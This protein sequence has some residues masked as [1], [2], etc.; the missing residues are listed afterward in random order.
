MECSRCDYFSLLSFFTW[1]FRPARCLFSQRDFP[2]SYEPAYQQSMSI[3]KQKII[4]TDEMMRSTPFAA[5]VV[6]SSDINNGED[7]LSSDNRI[8][9]SPLSHRHIGKRAARFRKMRWRFMM[10]SCDKWRKEFRLKQIK[11]WKQKFRES[12]RRN[13][14]LIRRKTSAL[15]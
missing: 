2:R 14:F 6:S 1:R 8:Q 7:K 3:W 15:Q 4:F 11:I 13:E 12:I 5:V 9:F 10:C